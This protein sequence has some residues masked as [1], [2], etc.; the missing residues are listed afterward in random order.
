M[1]G[2]EFRAVADLVQDPPTVAE[3][4]LEYV[5]N[6]PAA[7]GALGMRSPAIAA[8]R[9]AR[10]STERLSVRVRLDVSTSPSDLSL[11]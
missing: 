4:L 6:L 11:R 9:A 7:A 1:G 8:A 2:R 5:R 3:Q 10:L